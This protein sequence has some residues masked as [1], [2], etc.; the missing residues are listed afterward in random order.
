MI[1]LLIK[2][3]FCA[4]FAQTVF[5]HDL[6]KQIK[7]FDQVIEKQLQIVRNE[8]LRII[9]I[10]IQPVKSTCQNGQW[11]PKSKQCLHCET[12]PKVF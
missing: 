7:W 5:M 9:T 6:I 10:F 8:L 12:G 4:N 2:L 3:S 1:H 11:A